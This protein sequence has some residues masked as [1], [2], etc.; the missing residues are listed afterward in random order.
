MTIVCMCVHQWEGAAA[1]ADRVAGTCDLILEEQMAGC[2]WKA[3]GVCVCVFMG[4]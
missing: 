2:C 4:A 1:P 3:F